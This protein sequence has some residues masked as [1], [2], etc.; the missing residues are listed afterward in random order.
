MITF[1]M[2]RTALSRASRSPLLLSLATRSAG[3]ATMAGATSVRGRPRLPRRP[4]RAPRAAKRPAPPLQSAPQ[5]QS[6]VMRGAAL[7]GPALP[8]DRSS[9]S[10]LRRKQARS[11]LNV[12]DN[13]N[14][15]LCF[16]S[17][18]LSKVQGPPQQAASR[19]SSSQSGAA[20]RGARL[21]PSM[22]AMGS[23]RVG[24]ALAFFGASLGTGS[25]GGRDAR[26][27]CGRPTQGLITCRSP[28]AR[29]GACLSACLA[30]W[31]EALP[32]D[33]PVARPGRSGPSESRLRRL[34]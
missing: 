10:S 34:L 20:S 29:E 6:S 21:E 7:R 32:T 23:R 2:S 3:E 19:A 12:T 18:F 25:M 15:G 31:V 16:L 26:G 5:P 14:A 11:L 1:L 27:T 13:F 30:A 22:E 33:G 9:V 24:L 17:D 28:R 4:V 8:A